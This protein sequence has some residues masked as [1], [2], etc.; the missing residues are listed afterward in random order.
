[1][2]ASRNPNCCCH[3]LQTLYFMEADRMSSFPQ[4]NSIMN[5]GRALDQIPPPH[6][7]DCIQNGWSGRGQP[8]Q[9]LHHSAHP[10]GDGRKDFVQINR[11]IAICSQNSLEDRK[12]RAV[13]MK[14]H[15][16]QLLSQPGVQGSEKKQKHEMMG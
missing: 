5:P 16:D 11:T 13:Q 12:E 14:R 7:D 3:L 4:V 1:M 15:L 6:T 8:A 2:D 10:L 9:C